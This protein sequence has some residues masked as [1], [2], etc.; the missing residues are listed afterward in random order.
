M[1]EVPLA[2]VAGP[3]R[4]EKRWWLKTE[5]AVV[6]VATLEE[7]AQSGQCRRARGGNAV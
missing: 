2:V 7:A 3:L 4:F 6:T 1:R 5:N